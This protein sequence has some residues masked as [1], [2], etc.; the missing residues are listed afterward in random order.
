MI[1]DEASIARNQ[2]AVT[3]MHMFTT[4]L[5]WPLIIASVLMIAQQFSGIN[6]VMLYSTEIFIGAGLKDNCNE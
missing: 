6:A 1:D 5:R 4:N 3:I 2:P